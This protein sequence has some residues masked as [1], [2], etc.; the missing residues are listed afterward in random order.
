MGTTAVCN[1]LI[2]GGSHKNQAA[3]P[4]RVKEE[5]AK[6]KRRFDA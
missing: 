6:K 5:I 3:R 1:R 4:D 2:V